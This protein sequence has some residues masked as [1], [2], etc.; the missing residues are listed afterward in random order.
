MTELQ[1]GIPIQ[2]GETAPDG[3]PVWLYKVS[4]DGTRRIEPQVAGGSYW[5]TGVHGLWRR[6]PWNYAG[7]IPHMSRG[8]VAVIGVDHFKDGT[9]TPEEG[10]AGAYVHFVDNPGDTNCRISYGHRDSPTPGPDYYKVRRI[11]G[12]HALRYM[13]EN[14][15][16]AM[17]LSDPSQTR[18]HTVNFELT[19]VER[20]QAANNDY[21]IRGTIGLIWRLN[22]ALRIMPYGT[23]AEDAL[24]HAA[25]DEVMAL[26]VPFCALCDGAGMSYRTIRKHPHIHWERYQLAGLRISSDRDFDT[27]SLSHY[28]LVTA[29]LHRIDL[30]N[31]E[32]AADFASEGYADD[33][34]SAMPGRGHARLIPGFPTPQMP[35]FGGDLTRDYLVAGY[36]TVYDKF[37]ATPPGA[38][39]EGIVRKWIT[40]Q[41]LAILDER[42]FVNANADVG[43]AIEINYEFTKRLHDGWSHNFNTSHA[44]VNVFATPFPTYFWYSNPAFGA[45]RQREDVYMTD[46][47]DTPENSDDIIW[48]DTA[49]R[50]RRLDLVDQILGDATER[51]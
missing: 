18:I 27:T 7:Y 32:R 31:F 19:E 44:P 11:L 1:W 34:F 25:R 23:P 43:D 13:D 48:I 30:E 21:Q 45:L 36:R 29:E 9:L 10:E 47:P 17:R 41:L 33:D 22:E 14:P 26:L 12:E 20:R 49:E 39:E 6:C 37:K 16:A 28:G 2:G 35:D 24:W 8:G 4:A 51:V 38:F 42:N 50:D 40:L 3:L 5:S 15:I 46:A